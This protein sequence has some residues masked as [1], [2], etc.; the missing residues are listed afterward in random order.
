MK[1]CKRCKKEQEL[2]RFPII[3]KPNGK[4]YTANVCKSCRSE[5]RRN[6]R[7]N[8]SSVKAH[9]HELAKKR[10]NR[11]KEHYLNASKEWR[12]SEKG[13]INRMYHTSKARARKKGLEHTIEKSDIIIPKYCPILNTRLIPGSRG[14]YLN[15]PSLDRIDNSKGYTKDNIQVI[16]MKANSMKNSATKEELLLFAKW[17]LKTMMM[18]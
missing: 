9:E 11:N 17:V 10:Y 1:V 14:D 13:T 2:D 12:D 4:I 8:N 3:K 15:T 6:K 18:I 7:A 5:D 16:S